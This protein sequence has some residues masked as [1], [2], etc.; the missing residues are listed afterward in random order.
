[1][2]AASANIRICYSE[3]AP[4]GFVYY[5]H[6]T[7]WFEELQS[8]FL[9][10]I[11]YPVS[12]LNKSGINFMPVD[13]YSKYYLPVS[14]LRETRAEMTISDVTR[15]KVKILYTLYS[16]GKKAAESEVTYACLN[17]SLKPVIL[18][19]DQSE[20]YKILLENVGK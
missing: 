5:T 13:S 20:L 6:Y 2:S 3:L 14:P 18:S 17:D 4:N 7:R 11:G 1:M 15:V 16:G 10:S 19:K 12:S 9:D 8:S